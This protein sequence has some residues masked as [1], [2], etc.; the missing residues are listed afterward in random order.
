M[1]SVMTMDFR[2]L[3]TKPLFPPLGVGHWTRRTSIVEL[4][5]QRCL[6]ATCLGTGVRQ[7]WGT[8][9]EH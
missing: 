8:G 6:L 2:S 1:E 3:G 9:A 4:S 7:I 5:F